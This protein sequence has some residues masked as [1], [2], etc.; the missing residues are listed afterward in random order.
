MLMLTILSVFVLGLRSLAQQI[1]D[2]KVYNSRTNSSLG[3]NS[4]LG[5][6]DLAGIV[7]GESGGGGGGMVPAGALTT[8]NNNSSSHSLGTQQL[9][10]SPT[11]RES[12]GANVFYDQ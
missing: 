10:S 6:A 11:G 12:H 3:N 1:C 5:P 9:P 2:G 7:S 8:S 4:N